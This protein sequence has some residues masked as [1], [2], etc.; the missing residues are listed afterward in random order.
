MMNKMITLALALNAQQNELFFQLSTALGYISHLL[1]V[2][3]GLEYCMSIVAAGELKSYECVSKVW[4]C[5]LFC[6]S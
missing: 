6:M 4:G 3:L 1:V 5:V 2:L